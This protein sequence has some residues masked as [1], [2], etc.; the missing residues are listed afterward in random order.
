[1]A[2]TRVLVVDD[3]RLLAELSGTPMGRSSFDVRAVRPGQDI[4]A[5]A[6][7]QNPDVILLR[8]GEACPDGLEAVRRLRLD[9]VTREIPLIYIGLALDRDRYREAGVSVFIPRPV[10]RLDLQEAL[11]RVLVGLGKPLGQQARPAARRCGGPPRR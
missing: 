2:S 10:T 3:A 4:V 9:P 7:N 5:H 1:M 6:R 8:D 11:R